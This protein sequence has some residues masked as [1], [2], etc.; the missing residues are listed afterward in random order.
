[1]AEWETDE[2]GAEEGVSREAVAKVPMLGVAEN[3]ADVAT[4]VGGVERLELAEVKVKDVLMGLHD[5]LTKI[6]KT[7]PGI[8]EQWMGLADEALFISKKKF[9]PRNSSPASRA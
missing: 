3:V 9:A 4:L 2:G 5:K 1:M 7:Y 6:G 8:G